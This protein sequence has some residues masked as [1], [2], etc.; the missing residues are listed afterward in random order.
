M[1]I[2]RAIADKDMLTILDNVESLIGIG[3]IHDRIKNT[4]PIML[5]NANLSI[6]YYLGQIYE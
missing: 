4:Q 6:I 5:H 3:N 1:N 2:P